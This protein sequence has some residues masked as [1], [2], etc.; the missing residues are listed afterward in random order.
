MRRSALDLVRVVACAM[1]LVGHVS[2]THGD[3]GLVGLKNGVALFFVL[4]GYLL[5]R[6]FVIGDVD[7][8]QYAIRRVARIL[9]AY[10]VALIGLTIVTGDSTFARQPGTYLLFGQNYDPSLWQRFIGPSW[11]LVIEVHFYAALPLVAWAVRRSIPRLIALGASSWLAAAAIAL[12]SGP[13]WIQL[14][15]LSPFMLWAFV[16]GMAVAL[17]ED[18]MKA[19]PIVVLVVGVAIL[20]LGTAM[21]PWASVDLASGLGAGLI[22]AFA[23]RARIRSRALA[24][25]A[26]AGAALSYSVYLWHAD[27]L[28]A[29]DLGP[30]LVLTLVAA[31]VSY[32]AVERPMIL[33]GRRLAAGGGNWIGQVRSALRPTSVSA[34]VDPQ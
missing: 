11:T 25:V 20:A 13:G 14:S 24:L 16:P 17:L 5:Y 22:V 29:F 32:L 19:Q 12:L 21:G 26:S 1:V 9:P 4:S 34:P 3:G 31:T 2:T 6:P 15:S 33:A 28:H 18:R 27:V 10:L 30:A 23:A 8:L 7:L